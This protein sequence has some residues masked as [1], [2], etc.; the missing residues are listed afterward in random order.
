MKKSNLK[1]CFFTGIPELEHIS[2]FSFDWCRTQRLNVRVFRELTIPAPHF[3]LKETRGLV[4][5]SSSAIK[6]V[7]QRKDTVPPRT[8]IY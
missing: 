5:K 6:Q 1:K 8:E 2:S 7:V 3:D 4:I